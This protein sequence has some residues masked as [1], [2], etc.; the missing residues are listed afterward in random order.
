V[1][2]ETNWQSASYQLKPGDLCKGLCLDVWEPEGEGDGRLLGSGTSPIQD[3]FS[4]FPMQFE[5]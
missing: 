1:V 2:P 3:D 5:A 4:W